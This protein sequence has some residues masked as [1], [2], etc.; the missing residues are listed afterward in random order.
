MYSLYS[1]R[2]SFVDSE[3][4]TRNIQASYIQDMYDYITKLISNTKSALNL[5]SYLGDDLWKIFCSY[6]RED[7]YQNDNYISDGLNNAELLERANELYDT[8]TKELYKA[9]NPQYSLTSTINNLL[10]MK[11]F[12]P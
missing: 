4:A 7:K 3:L 10:N 2:K 8:A 12:A 6:R 9:S 5:Q 1:K 11:E